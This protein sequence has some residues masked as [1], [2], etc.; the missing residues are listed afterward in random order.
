MKRIQPPIPEM[1][2]R[3]KEVMIT[4]RGSAYLSTCQITL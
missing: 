2:D 1:R 4:Q 3:I